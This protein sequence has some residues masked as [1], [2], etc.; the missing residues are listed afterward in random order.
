MRAA[1]QR[2]RGAAYGGA[3]WKE[4]VR[5]ILG[6]IDLEALKQDALEKLQ[7]RALQRKLALSLVDIGYKALATK[8]HPDKGGSAEAM[9]RLN[10]VRKLLQD[11]VTV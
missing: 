3:G 9:A 6:K 8:L 1:G 4:P 2:P 5:E 10:R 7:E 11:A